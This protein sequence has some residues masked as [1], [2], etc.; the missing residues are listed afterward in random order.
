MITVDQGGG[1]YDSGY[2]QP[3]DFFGDGTRIPFVI[4]SPWTKKGT[5]NHDY[6]DHAS[7]LKFIERNW[8]LEP[9]SERSRDNLPNPVHGKYKHIYVPKTVPAI[10]DLFSLFDCDQEYPSH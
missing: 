8:L 5:V 9:L 10:S 3:I 2:V 7:I 6:S 1:Y 4:V